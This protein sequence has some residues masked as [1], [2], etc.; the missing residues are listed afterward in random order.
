[1]RREQAKSWPDEGSFDDLIFLWSYDFVYGSPGGEVQGCIDG[2]FARHGKGVR[3]AVEIIDTEMASS[4]MEDESVFC[5]GGLLLRERDVD[6]VKKIVDDIGPGLG[7][8]DTDGMSVLGLLEAPQVFSRK[9]E[10]GNIA[11]FHLGRR[12]H[13]KLAL[14]MIEKLGISEMKL[15]LG[16]DDGRRS[17]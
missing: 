4:T 14:F 7:E 1:M 13:L 2:I 17:L 8:P 11:G 16:I 9:G 12:H 5:S 3:A 6:L 10:K 15:A